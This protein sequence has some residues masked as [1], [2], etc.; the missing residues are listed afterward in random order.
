MSKN[1][2]SDKKNSFWKIISQLARRYEWFVVGMSFLIVTLLGWHGFAKLEHDL[3]QGRS[4]SWSDNLYLSFQLFVLQSGDQAKVGLELNVARFLAP[5][6]ALWATIRTIAI[7]LEEHFNVFWL[8]LFYRNHVVICGLGEKGMK[9]VQHSTGKGERIVVIEKDKENDNIAGCLERGTIVLIGDSS[10]EYL[11]REA[12]V[13]RAK[14]IIAVTRDD[15]TNIKTALKTY[16]ILKQ[17]K[18]SPAKKRMVDCF[19]HIYDIRLRELFEQHEF[20]TKTSENYQAR[21]FNIYDESARHILAKY[22]PDRFGKDNKPGGNQIRVLIIGFGWTG[23]S[24]AKQAVRVCHY[25]NNTPTEIKIVDISADEKKERFLSSRSNEDKSFIVNDIKPVF[26]SKDI[27]TLHS[28]SELRIESE[29]FPSVV[30]VCLGND[31]VGIT[32]AVRLR[33]LLGANPPIVVCIKSGEAALFDSKVFSELN[34]N[35]YAFDMLSHICSTHIDTEEVL[36]GLARMVHYNYLANAKEKGGQNLTNWENLTEDI[37]DSNRCQADHLPVKLR[38]IDAEEDGQ[39]IV[40][41][42]LT[43]EDNYKMLAEMEHRRWMAEKLLAGWRYSNKR[44]DL[45][46]LHNDIVE[47]DG[48]KEEKQKDVDAIKNIPA[49]ISSESWKSYKSSIFLNNL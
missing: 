44:D 35:I 21:L 7:F 32:T 5:L 28:L 46:K 1:I 23:E 8:N 48:L 20:F 11:L 31:T 34:K 10:D 22:A 9:L 4:Y 41:E 13:N 17:N 29:K 36:D 38:A 42:K 24:I 3:A 6:L 19:V 12:R 40:A 18:I 25:A 14:K 15:N 27:E 33:K 2:I 43:S 30:Y 39:Q 26:I 49:L 37:K 16:E 47:F 45:K